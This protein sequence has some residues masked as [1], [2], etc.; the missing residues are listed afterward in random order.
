MV[1]V[2]RSWRRLTRRAGVSFG[3]LAAAYALLLVYPQPLFAYQ[4]EQGGIVVHAR[5]PIPEA[6]RDTLTKVRARLDRSPLYDPSQTSHVFICEP[7]WVFALFARTNYRVGGIAHGLIGRHVFLR[8]SD[9]DHDR[10]IGPSGQ[11]VAADRPLSYFMA[12]E[13][14]HIIAAR[15]LGLLAYAR[16]PKWVNDG[17][18]D[19]VARDIDLDAALQGLKNG[20]RELDPLRSGLYLRY[21]LMI[22]YLLNVR[23]T[24]LKG[25]LQR[26]DDGRD[27][28][29]ALSS[30]NVYPQ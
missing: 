29:Q 19:Y 28:E 27:V 16:L 24:P 14:T 20:V 4:L 6:M 25:V 11:P 13:L 9:M 3:V 22:A 18:A 17:Y 30:L 15:H 7:R 23:R 5:R 10:L 2:K 8:E 21:H 1:P 12:H 26:V